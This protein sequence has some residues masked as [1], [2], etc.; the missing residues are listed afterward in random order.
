MGI[1]Y[2]LA[3][4]VLMVAFLLL[5]KSEKKLNILS[6][7]VMSTVLYLAY[8]I[9]L[10]FILGAVGLRVNLLALTLINLF[11]S[12]IIGLKIIDDEAMQKYFIRKQDILAFILIILISIF[13][14]IDQ[15]RPFD[16]TVATASIDGP[17]HYSAATN[18][19]DNMIIL[20]KIDNTT[21]YNFLTMQ[22]GAYINTGLLMNVIRNS[23]IDLKDFVV[24]KCFEMGIFTL[25]VL[26]FYILIENKLTSKYKTIIGLTFLT[27]YAFAYPYTSLLYGFSYLSLSIVFCVAML[28]LAKISKEKEIDFKYELICIIF[29]GIGIIFSY[30]LF[31]PCMFAFIC[32]NTFLFDKDDKHKL[33][34]KKAILVTGTL[35]VVTVVVSDETVVVVFSVISGTVV[36]I[37]SVF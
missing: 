4:L 2:I 16:K 24:F 34:K 17:M 11:I 33:F 6:W 15:Y 5:K 26:V 14:S 18:F 10:F 36:I 9:L 13:V 8:N 23:P 29:A 25:N 1:L 35:L 31:V 32:I 21:G 7:I 37:G 28:Y 30:C 22:P 20:A 3:T 12:M 19:A 27:L